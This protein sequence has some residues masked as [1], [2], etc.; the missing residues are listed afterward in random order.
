MGRVDSAQNLKAAYAFDHW[1]SQLSDFLG[2]LNRS[3]IHQQPVPISR[4][5]L[6]RGENV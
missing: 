4:P 1:V 2:I 5:T 6:E 3:P